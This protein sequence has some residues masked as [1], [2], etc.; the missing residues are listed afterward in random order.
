MRDLIAEVFASMR[1]NRQR[2]ALTG[3]SIGWG[4]FIL[5]I[6]LGSSS[7]FKRGIGKTFFLD[8]GQFVSVT[9]GKT[10]ESW[11]GLE[12][13]RLI[14]LRA[15]D[16]VEIENSG[17]GHISQVFPVAV[18]SLQVVNGTSIL[19]VPVT[20]CNGGYLGI[21]Y[22]KLVGG[23]DIDSLD[24]RNCG[25]VCILNRRLAGQ[26]FQ[27]D[28]P[29]GRFVRVDDILYR[30]V[31]VCES[32]LS[33]DYSSAMYIPFSTMM[34]IYRPDGV[35]DKIDIAVAGLGTAQANEDFDSEIHGFVASLHG[36]SPTDY[37]GIKVSN[38]Y[39]QTLSA[40]NMLSGIGIFVWIIGIATLVG[41]IVGVSNIMLITVKERTRELGVRKA[42]GTGA[43]TIIRMVLMESVIITVIFG[44]IGLMAAV[45]LTQLLDMALGDVFPMFQNPTVDFWPV[46]ICNFIMV[47]AGIVAGY[48]PA[49]RAVSIKLVD[50]LSS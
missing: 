15:S 31:G 26:L 22:R 39:E 6:L 18:Q 36:C 33:Q 27:K 37:K 24:M 4:M 16:A 9:S 50:A 2:I 42:L 12:K 3:F 10:A 43:A 29:L 41:G 49:K 19:T 25:K 32:I 14:R 46:M 40:G 35:V 13:G 20:G 17:I 47:L 8:S 28:D 21:N 30:V 11:Q 7:G 45:G 44:S 1:S 38:Q 5:V 23:R 34:S 48:I